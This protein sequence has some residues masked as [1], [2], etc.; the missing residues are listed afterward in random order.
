ESA[1]R[2]TWQA[3]VMG[4]LLLSL[5]AAGTA[6]LLLG[7]QTPGSDTPRPPGGSPSAPG[8]VTGAPPPPSGGAPIS[9][10]PSITALAS[11]AVTPPIEVCCPQGEKQCKSGRTCKA[12]G[13]AAHEVPERTFVPRIIAVEEE[14]SPYEKKRNLADRSALPESTVCVRADA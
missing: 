10:P 9:G 11:A 2:G 14:T 4:L 13:C 8:P 5:V 1:N 6:W 12:E 7:G 3:L